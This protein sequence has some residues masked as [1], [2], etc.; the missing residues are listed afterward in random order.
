MLISP[1]NFE[2]RYGRIADAD[3]VLKLYVESVGELGVS[4]V[5]KVPTQASIQWLIGMCKRCGFP[6][7]TLRHEGKLVAWAMIR[8]IAWG[9]EVCARTG[10]FS[11]YVANEWQG[12]GVPIYVI[13]CVIRDVRR[14]GFD[15]ITAWIFANNRKSLN[16]ARAMRM[17][18]WAKMPRVADFGGI[19]QDLE[20]WGLDLDDPKWIAFQEAH[21][22]RHARRQRYLAATVRPELAEAAV[23]TA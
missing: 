4:P 6:F 13:R 1:E 20:V 12:K 7:W 2:W 5:I 8:A 17:T 11:I 3:D 14:H 22:A 19:K 21:E 10:D 9:P 16:V 15:I 23:S 18:R